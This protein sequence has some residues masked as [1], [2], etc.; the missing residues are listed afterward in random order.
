MSAS[1]EQCALP[2]LI[3]S[4]LM[5]TRTIS[6]I[7]TRTHPITDWFLLPDGLQMANKSPME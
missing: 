5:G 6:T 1:S 4:I 7:A 2:V 3:T